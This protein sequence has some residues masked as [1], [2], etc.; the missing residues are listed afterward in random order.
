MCAICHD[1]LAI[2]MTVECGHTYC[3]SCLYRWAKDLDQLNLNCPTCR[4]SLVSKP[5]MNLAL[6]KQ[7]EQLISVLPDAESMEIA[8]RLDEAEGLFSLM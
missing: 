5:V 2:P 7:I 8:T 4:H 1:V 6:K 3:F